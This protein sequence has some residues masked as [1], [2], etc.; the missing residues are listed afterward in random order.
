MVV[1]GFNC[2]GVVVQS[3][4]TDIEAVFSSLF[5]FLVENAKVVFSGDSLAF[6]LVIFMYLFF[7]ST[8]HSLLVR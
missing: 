6:Q 3:L 5:C 4:L 1:D 7:W 8:F 2:R